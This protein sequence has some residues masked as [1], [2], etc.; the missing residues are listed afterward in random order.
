MTEA[1]LQ[2]RL[3]AILAVDVAGY[4]LLMG[5][6]EVGTLAAMK[7]TWSE[8]FDPAVAKY[9]GRIIKKM[10]DGALV[11]FASAVDAVDCAIA[12]QNSML[13]YNE[14]GAH[15]K[16]IEF[17][18]GVNVGD[19]VVDDDDI[20]GDGVNIAA[21]LEGQAPRTGVL[22]SDSV[23]TQLQGESRQDFVTVGELQLK[24]IKVPVK[25]WSWGGK[26]SLIEL[27]VKPF[28]TRAWL[29]M[30]LSI[31]VVVIAGLGFWFQP[32]QP[33]R[34][35]ADPAN[36]AYSLPEK[37][38]IAVLP[39]DN[40]S[41][42]KDQEY[43]SDG[44]TEDIITDLSKIS[45]L[46]VIARNSSFSY[47]NQAVKISQVAEELGVSYVLEG[48]VRRVGDQIRINAQ[49]ID[50]ISGGHI[51]ADRYDGNATDIFALQDRITSTIVKEL[52][53]QLLVQEQDILASKET[54][55]A[56]AYD[57]FLIGNA[58]FQT[59]S[60]E[61][62]A[63][64]KE[65]F[66]KA[67]T[68]DPEYSRAWAQLARLYI[69]S[70]WRGFAEELELDLE[71]VP[72]LLEKALQKPTPEAYEAQ[73]GWLSNQT[74]TAEIQSIIE[75]LS[76]LDPNYAG[77][78]N[79]RGIL[80]AFDGQP[81][82]AINYSKTALRLDPNS[83]STLI[84]LARFNIQLARNSVALRLLEQARALQ[85]DDP[86]Y[87]A[88]LAA[89]NALLGRIDEAK[90]TAGQLIETRNSIG[91]VTITGSFGRWVLGHPDYREKLHEG[92]LLAGITDRAI[93]EDLNLLPEHRL[94]G[95]EL[96]A[97]IESGRASIGRSPGGD[98]KVE[99]LADGTG[100]HYWLGKEFARSDWSVEDD[101]YVLNYR[102]PSKRESY[103][104]DT[105]RNPEGSKE[106]L[107]EYIYI[108]TIGVFLHS[109]APLF[110]D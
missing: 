87:L 90:K 45:G 73:I 51:W 70:S 66:E 7:V 22:I 80:A 76:I 74:R 14:A 60:L 26:A 81:E 94:T 64:A 34:E 6:D 49:L 42:D 104:C 30:G 59:T 71:I 12:I 97:L 36:M 33:D 69:K 19:I 3:S 98:W 38:S 109:H 8:Y 101:E 84:L 78:Y 28:L 86:G 5:D 63:K 21:R 40:L 107:N 55:V 23:Y 75:Q 68:L 41:A 85:P 91:L 53:I 110:G 102:P 82:L 10:G 105:Y 100:I 58:H 46:F 92:L 72:D 61:S 4:S 44:V 11:E 2:R 67:V 96:L 32:W 65:A 93:P 1:R 27:P 9:Q 20:F 52:S 56:A 37:P 31:L 35:R 108:C 62:F 88:D 29:V 50:A 54:N 16:P 83:S 95:P 18:I 47:K 24:N 15:D 13:T 39:F 57:L 25:A 79:W 48:S 17:R 89:A 43:F 103:R 77:T 99:N 106:E